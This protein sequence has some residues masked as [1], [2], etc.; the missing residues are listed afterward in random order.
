MNKKLLSKR[1][2]KIADFV[3]QYAPKPTRLADIGTDHALLPCYLMDQKM[4]NFAVASDV[5]PGPLSAARE[6]INKQGFNDTI[7]LR[8]ASGLDGLEAHDQI[9]AV[10]ICGMGGQLIVEIL[11]DGL[12]KLD[13]EYVLVLQSNKAGHLI[14]E[15][16]ERSHHIFDEAVVE[17]R[18]HFYEILVAGP[19][20]LAE[21]KLSPE[22]KL[23]GPVNLRKKTES[24]I[25]MWDFEYDH[26]LRILHN[27]EKSQTIKPEDLETL[28]DKIS[29]IERVIA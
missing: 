29:M 5:V 25:K 14:R 6:E 3:N 21:T 27:M 9:N 7:D 13:S 12:E 10:T 19:S 28:R 23:F 11:K 16:L 17:E 8:L 1:L 2:L 26:A 24:F 20:R 18:G 22:E 4:I 15:F